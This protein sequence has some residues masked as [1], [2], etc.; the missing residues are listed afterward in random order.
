[1]KVAY[2]ECFAGIAG[3]MFLGAL[4]DAGVDPAMLQMTADSLALGVTLEFRKVDRS[5][6]QSTK[7]RVLLHGVDADAPA[8]SHN[9]HHD[10]HNDGHSHAHTHTHVDEH[11]VAHTH[12]HEHSHAHAEQKPHVHGRSLSA[13]RELIQG[14]SLTARARRIALEAF[15]RLGAAEAKIH[16]VPVEAV[17]FHEVGAVDAIID[18]VCSAAGADA[19]GVEAWYCSPVNTGSG[20]VDC[21][22]GRFPVPAPATLELLHSVPVYAAGPAKEFTTPTGAA[23]I[24]ALGCRFDPL[25]TLMTERTGYGAGTRN[26]DGFPNVL[27]LRI[28]EVQCAGGRNEEKKETVTVLECA[29]DD[30]T[31]ETLAFAAQSLMEH[32]ALDVMQQPVFMK[33]GRQGT[34]LTVICHPEDSTH[35]QQVLFRETTTLGI[36]IRHEE[37]AVLDRQ[38]IEVETEFGKIRV[39]L[40]L[41]DGIVFNV[42]PEFEDCRRAAEARRIP[43]KQVMQAVLSAFAKA[44]E[45]VATR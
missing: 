9:H 44:Q 4:V 38:S 37:R 5:G 23:L 22:H 35:L 34:L 15:A 19:L 11:G 26:P 1:M 29:M 39:K 16:G 31:P 14:A 36:R 17:H 28:G 3:D 27:R 21:A 8:T 43:L 20:F 33:K 41:R 40:G 13:I 45:V 10:R 24:A 12:T 6:I 32:N 7:A 42:A 30:A 2:L 25:P 18:I